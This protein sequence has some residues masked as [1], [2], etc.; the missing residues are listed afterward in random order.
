MSFN[1]KVIVSQNLKDLMKIAKILIKE[2]YLVQLRYEDCGNYTLE[3][4][5]TEL[6][7]ASGCYVYMTQDEYDAYYAQTVCSDEDDE[8]DEEIADDKADGNE[9]IADND[10]DY[11]YNNHCAYDEGYEKGYKAGLSVGYQK[12][13]DEEN[14]DGDYDRDNNGVYDEGYQ[15]GYSNGYEDGYDEG[16]ETGLNEGDID[17]VRNDED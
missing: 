3:Y 9:E 8:D 5:Q 15:D 7:L 11:H 10:D 2:G 13:I 1:E 6:D 17:C 14:A 12:R 4:E 16:Y